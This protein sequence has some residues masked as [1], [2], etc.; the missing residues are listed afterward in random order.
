MDRLLAGAVGCLH[1]A[2][3]REDGGVRLQLLQAVLLEPGEQRALPAAT[4]LGHAVDW[5][6]DFADLWLTIAADSFVACRWETVYHLAL[7]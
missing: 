6:D 3:E 7:E 1:R 2:R 4:R 5:L